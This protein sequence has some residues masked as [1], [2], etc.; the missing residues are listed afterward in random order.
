MIACK[1]VIVQRHAFHF[2]RSSMAVAL[3]TALVF[4]LAWVVV[5]CAVVLAASALLTVGRA[6][7]IVLYR[8][9]LGRAWPGGSEVLDER[10]MRF[11]H[12]LGAVICAVC[13]GLIYAAPRAGYT[14]LAFVAVAKTSGALG[15]CSGLK[16]YGCLNSETCCRW[17][18]RQV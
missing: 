10:A 2:C 14:F 16:L 15:Y 6:P 4:Q 17:V 7:L 18:G 1:P 13:A 11:A 3:W 8:E 5:A 12:T 9:T